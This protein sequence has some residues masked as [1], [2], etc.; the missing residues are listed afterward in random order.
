ME[1]MEKI[2]IIGKK[3]AKKSGEIAETGKLSMNIKKKERA[4]RNL[5]LELGKYVYQQCKSGV[6]TDEKI[7]KFCS[8]IDVL[9]AEIASLELEKEK[10]GEDSDYSEIEII[11]ADLDEEDS[12]DLSEETSD[13]D[14]FS[15]SISDIDEEKEE[16]AARSANDDDADDDEG[17]DASETIYDSDNFS[18][19]GGDIF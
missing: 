16:D 19:V 13:D 17:Y 5:K 14:L 15:D 10:V 4:V 3:M 9:Y 2:N 8:E 7:S 11:T 1:F 6:S 12:D 18:E